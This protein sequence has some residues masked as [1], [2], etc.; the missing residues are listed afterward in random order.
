MEK[1]DPNTRWPKRFELRKVLSC[2]L[3]G[4][5]NADEVYAL[6]SDQYKLRGLEQAPI[7]VPVSVSGA[8]FAI[9]LE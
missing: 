7:G 8:F 9:R 1:P 4:A 6:A 5:K 3:V 2:D